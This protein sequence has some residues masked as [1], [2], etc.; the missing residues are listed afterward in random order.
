MPLQILNYIYRMPF[1]YIPRSIEPCVLKAAKQF[2]GIVLTG[3]RQSGKTTLLRHL[4]PSSSFISLDD[5][6]IRQQALED[7]GILFGEGAGA[8]CIIDEIQYVPELTTHIKMLIDRERQAFGRFFI[9][10]SQRF[11]LM[12]NLGDSLAGRVALLELLPFDEQEAVV[13]R[14]PSE[15]VELFTEACLNS[16]FPEPFCNRNDERRLW[17]GS[18]FQTYIERDVRTL[19][20]VGDLRDFTRFV[21]LLAARVSQ[22]LNMSSLASDVGISVNTIKRWVSILESSRVIYLLEPWFSN[23]GK[24]IVKTPKVYFIDSGLVC[25][26]TGISTKEVLLDGPLAGHLFENYCITETIKLFDNEG[27]TP[28]MYFFKT[29]GGAEIDLIAETGQGG[30]YLAECKL[31][32]T[33]MPAMAAHL[34]KTGALLFNANQIKGRTVVTCSPETR[35][36]TPHSKAMSSAEFLKDLRAFI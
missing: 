30:Y 13:A 14:G 12:K 8:S 6:L 26:L 16:R 28:R 1:N 29:H 5:P 22:E 34:E 17:Y 25:F 27:T 24:R 23:I 32:A 18:Y 7:P 31:S 35:A 19:G 4:F 15:P 11:A 20:N 36:L 3:P 9:T 21:R 10:G 2:P 33:P